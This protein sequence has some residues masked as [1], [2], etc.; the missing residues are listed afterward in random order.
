MEYACD[1]APSEQKIV[2]NSRSKL[3]SQQPATGIR[4]SFVLL[5]RPRTQETRSVNTE[6]SNR[7]FKQDYSECP[8]TEDKS[9]WRPYC[10][11]ALDSSYANREKNNKW[12]GH[13]AADLNPY[14]CVYEDCDKPN[15][16]YATTDEWKRHISN[17]HRVPRWYCVACWP[18]SVDPTGFEFAIEEEWHDHSVTEHDEENDEVDLPDMAEASRRRAVPPVS[19][20][21]CF[22]CTPLLQSETDGNIAKH[23][24]SFALQ[25]LPW[26]TIGSDDD[27]KTYVDS[28]LKKTVPLDG[29][30]ELGDEKVN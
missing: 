11:Q 18:E 14:I 9:L 26:E 24:H 17:R 15:G 28:E 2:N 13:I 27:T 1:V 16:M 20:L 19:C 23:L 6:F 8:T 4:S 29:N 21:L 25:T 12:R 3:S 30:D 7:M 10:D 22:E 5:Q